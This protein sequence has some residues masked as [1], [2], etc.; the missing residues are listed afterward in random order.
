[1]IHMALTFT[2]PSRNNYV[3]LDDYT[4]PVPILVV[5]KMSLPVGAAKGEVA[6][7]LDGRGTGQCQWLWRTV[8]VKSG[9]ALP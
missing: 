3:Y 4:A 7:G 9:M 2:Q 5:N 6:A 8:H 1:M